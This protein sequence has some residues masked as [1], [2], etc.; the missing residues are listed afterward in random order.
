MARFGDI[1]CRGGAGRSSSR[2]LGGGSLWR[3][4]SS[5]GRSSDS[6]D[7]PSLGKGAAHPWCLAHG[8]GAAM[9]RLARGTHRRWQLRTTRMCWICATSTLGTSSGVRPGPVHPA[10]TTSP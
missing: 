8:T 6:P 2:H 1:L 9:C 7:L 3:Q 4:S 10:S 5:L